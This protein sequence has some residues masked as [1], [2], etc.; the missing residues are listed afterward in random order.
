M[1]RP[2]HAEIDL[3]SLSLNIKNI[4]TKLDHNTLF[5]AVV[6]SNAYGH[7]LETVSSYIEKCHLADYLGVAIP[8]E[9]F[10]LR[11][12]GIKLPILILGYSP[13]AYYSEIVDNNLIPT[14]FS[15]EMVRDFRD[16]SKQKGKKSRVHFKIETGMNRLGFKE[17]QD[18]KEALSILKD[19]EQYLELDGVFTHFAT[20]EIENQEYTNFQYG[21]FQ[22]R[23]KLVHAFGFNPILHASNSGAILSRPDLQFNMVRCGIAMYGYYP[24]PE[25]KCNL[26]LNPVLTWKTSISNVKTIMPGETVSYGRT[27]TASK[28]MKVATLSV[29]YGDGYKRN[30]SNVGYV[31]IKGEKAPVIGTVCMDQLMCD[32]TELQVRRDD[33]AVLIGKS[34]KQYISADEMARWSGTI[35]YEILLSI[36]ERVPREYFE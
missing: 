4:K 30:I 14:L 2:T 28:P 23:I 29:G 10:A 16:V 18:L 35:S 26:P 32:V 36:S 20:S 7:G 1:L 25:M 31:L 19:S 9:G 17:V 22:E 27:F 11:K 12:A 24:D 13:S 6:K 15:P 34:G 5:M 21:I 3:K 33:E 8:E